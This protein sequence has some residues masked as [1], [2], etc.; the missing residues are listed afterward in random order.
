MKTTRGRALRLAYVRLLAGD[1]VRA[2]IVG[3]ASY[4]LIGWA[5]LCL[6]WSVMAPGGASWLDHAF[7][8]V[9]AVSTTGLATVS[10]GGVYSGFGQGVVLLLIQLGGLGYMTIS[11]C[12]LLAVSGRLPVWRE[13][14]GAACL[15]LPPS[16]QVGP[17]LRLAVG[18]TLV[19]E[20]VGAWLLHGAFVRAGVESAWWQAIFHSVSA[21][22]TAGFSLFSNGI[23][24]FRDD[25]G[26]NLILIALSYLGAIGFIVIHDVWTSLR[27]LRA[28]VTLTTR[29]IL[30][31]TT[32]IS[33]GG[34]ILV[35]CDE[36]SV[37]SLSLGSRWMAAWFQVMSASTT[38]GFNTVPIADFSSANLFLLT[39]I[40]I[41]GASPAGTGGGLKTTTI[42]ALWA[43]GAAVIRGRSR[44]SFLG[45]EIPVARIR[46]AVAATLFYALT[47][48]AGIYAL[49]LAQPSTVLADLVFEVISALGTVGLSRGI[50]GD[51]SETAKVIVTVLMFM[52]RAGPL[53][54]GTAL[55]RGTDDPPAPEEDVV[56]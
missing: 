6:P 40:M 11:S 37:A 45:R 5:L 51:L 50:T 19:M 15:S 13:R 33:I 55:F 32:L 56:V 21:F 30:T 24:G 49:S 9:S 2:V 12:V 39:V 1:P 7:T 14:V 38:V 4:V 53:V 8:A 23:E 20:A 16:F 10:T 41:I 31:S 46:M 48:A 27:H 35:A 42:T 28:R 17:F 44:V 22:C 34:T 47:L 3:Y 25:V 36:P 29:V 52:G 18:Y 26:V 54:L 43:V